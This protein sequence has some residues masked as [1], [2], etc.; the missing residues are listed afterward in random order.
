MRTDSTTGAATARPPRT[1]FHTPAQS[2]LS[3]LLQ[4]DPLGAQRSPLA[5]PV[6]ATGAPAQTTFKLF[7]HAGA[8]RALAAQFISRRFCESFGARVEAFMPR[9]FGMYDPDG[10]LRGALGLRSARH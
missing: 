3:R 1:E 10:K 7:E 2:L 9:L 6:A 5:R 4:A 8:D